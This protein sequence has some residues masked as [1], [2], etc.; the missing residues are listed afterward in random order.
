MS[1]QPV[2]QLRNFY[3]VDLFL[4]CTAVCISQR[5]A[6]VASANMKRGAHEN[7]VRVLIAHR[8]AD[9]KGQLLYFKPPLCPVHFRL[10]KMLR[11]H[12]L[13]KLPDSAAFVFCAVCQPFQ[14]LR[15]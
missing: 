2:K 10:R 3:L 12:S 11:I 5:N 14:I 9:R 7:I 4:L 8:L 13:R 6:A 15:R 1:N